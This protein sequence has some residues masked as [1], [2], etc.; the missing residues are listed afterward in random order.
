[1]RRAVIPVLLALVLATGVWLA[2]C[3]R[4]SVGVPAGGSIQAAID[5]AP[6]GST[7][8]LDAG[9]YNLTAQVTPKSGDVLEG[10]GSATILDG[11][12][13]R[14]V[15]GGPG[16]DVTIRDLAVTGGL[17]GVR[18]RTGW[19]VEGVSSYGNDTGLKGIAAT[20]ATLSGNVVHDNRVGI[21]L[22]EN[23]TGVLIAHNAVSASAAD[24]IRVE[25]SDGNRVAFNEVDGFIRLLNSDR[26]V[27]IG[28]SVSGAGAAYPVE[29]RASGRA[30]YTAVDNQVLDNQIAVA[31]AQFIGAVSTNQGPVAGTVFDGNVYETDGAVAHWKLYDGSKNVAYTFAAWQAVGMDVHGSV[32]MIP[33]PAQR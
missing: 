6:P 1:M 11:V 26:N 15:V 13:T 29:V 28:N 31:S 32:R 20:G 7:I 27:V 3:G 33:N 8:G 17:Q 23:D 5:A 30:G 21:W 10:Q 16:S 19:T 4:P 22:D 24:G 14:A 12:S 25:I 9:T 2:G 18:F